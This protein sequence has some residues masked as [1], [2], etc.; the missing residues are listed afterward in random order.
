M[1]SFFKAILIITLIVFIW[2]FRIYTVFKKTP[3]SSRQ[4]TVV[5]NIKD[6]MPMDKIAKR[7]KK[8]G[9]I[10]SAFLFKVMTIL[11][12]NETKLKSG[13]YELRRNMS[14]EEIMNI[15]KSGEE[16]KYYITF[17]EGIRLEEIAEKLEKKHLVKK[18]EFLSLARNRDFIK[19]LGIDAISLEGYLFPDTYAFTKRSG[20]RYIL[21]TMV[22]E[23]KK[24]ITPD[25][26]A[27]MKSMGMNLHQ[28]LTIASMI[29]KETYL[30]EEKPIIAAVFYNRLK[31]GMLLQCD[32]TVIY[33][34]KKFNS[35]LYRKDLNYDSPY[36]TYRYSGLPPGPICNPGEKSIR[37]ALNPADV[38]YL[39]FVVAGEGRHK[40]S[41]TYSEHLNAVNEYKL[42]QKQKSN[43]K[44]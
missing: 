11:E 31:K 9:L 6:N 24:R 22:R 17:P 38:D 28:I 14:P 35:R 20:A 13:E 21:R 39:Y 29:E 19:S 4:R 34:K 15:L 40:F 18:D 43:G 37:A 23:L 41:K 1:K 32:P 3:C 36:N 26:E 27:K 25:D 42:S 7:L 44:L 30:D 12:G 5:L 10:S 8:K 2:V 16:K 33:A